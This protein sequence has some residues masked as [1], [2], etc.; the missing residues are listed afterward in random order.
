MSTNNTRY[1]SLEYER[2]LLGPGLA[3]IPRNVVWVKSKLAIDACI[4]Y[5]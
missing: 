4:T 3:E 2:D 5:I 1:Y